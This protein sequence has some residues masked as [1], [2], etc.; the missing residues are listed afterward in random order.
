[1]QTLIITK[2]NLCLFTHI[3]DLKILNKALYNAKKQK[4]KFKL[5]RKCFCNE[6]A[7]I[8]N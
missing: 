4:A 5:Y 6:L 3:Y 2:F 7:T 8:W 1:M